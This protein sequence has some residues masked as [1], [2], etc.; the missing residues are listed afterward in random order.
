MRQSINSIRPGAIGLMLSLLVTVSGCS[1]LR[2]NDSKPPVMP[3]YQQTVLELPPDVLLMDC[4]VIF[5][6][7]LTE[8]LMQGNATGSD[9][10]EAIARG[11]GSLLDC[12]GE[13]AALRH[14]KRLR[15]AQSGR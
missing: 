12:N 3:I 13:K 1:L 4:E 14:W 7:N 9:Y 10:E 11:Y 8:L 5:Y 15:E 6:E 2:S